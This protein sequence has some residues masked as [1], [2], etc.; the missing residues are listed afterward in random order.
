MN[1]T[2]EYIVERSFLFRPPS[3]LLK[4]GTLVFVLFFVLVL[5]FASVLKFNEVVDAQILITSE[6]PPVNLF[7]RQR[8][9]LVFLNFRQ[10]QQ[11]DK[12]EVL[13]VIE[14][15]S[16]YE[17]VI[18][19]DSMLAVS[20]LRYM[21]LPALYSD[22][23]SDLEL[24][25]DLHKSYQNFLEAYRKYLI[26]LELDEEA[27]ESQNI[28]MRISR[29][30]RQIGFKKN[31]LTTL[32]RN[33]RIAYRKVERQKQLLEKGVISDQEYELVLQE[34]NAARNESNRI[35]QEL[36]ELYVDTLSLYNLNQKA[37]NRNYISGSAY[38]SDLQLSKQALEAQIKQWEN[39]YALISPL[40]GNV[41]VFDVW[42]KYQNVNEGEHVITV[43]PKESE[44]LIGKCKVPIRNSAKIEKGQQVVIK[45]ENYPYQE[46]GMVKGFV[47]SISN[48]PKKE[49]ISYYS[50]YVDIDEL[51]T[52][53]GKNIEFKQEMFGSAKIILDET[54]LLERIFYQFRGLWS[55]SQY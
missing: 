49:E 55:N 32:N 41:T 5:L 36:E 33:L 44:R 24:E 9:K 54:S 29:Q 37:S 30:R 25:V 17:D 27:A 52:T 3:F 15:P 48:T 13:A 45:L 16:R 18:Y 20:E 4:W 26:Y 22:F 53:Y 11:V 39:N 42:N 2:K 31:Q 1:R 12:D 43:V 47:R 8:G 21:S 19:L 7:S 14:N 28:G 50:V 34:F 51:K 38:Y 40:A 10:G 46:W 23:P 35:R 6:N